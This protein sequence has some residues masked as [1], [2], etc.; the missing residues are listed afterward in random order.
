M[1]NLAVI[2]FGKSNSGKTTTIRAFA[3][4]LLSQNHCK[5][6]CGDINQKS[7]FLV[8][9]NADGTL[10]GIASGGDTAEIINHNLTIF[11]QKGCDIII[12]AAKSSGKTHDEII[13]L[14]S[15]FERIW[16]RQR[17]IS[18]APINESKEERLRC[19]SIKSTI[20]LIHSIIKL[21][22]AP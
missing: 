3:E 22:K 1:T 11:L 8:C 19:T 18:I 12:T 7:D 10:I 6:V 20:E 17:D 9:I 14:C 2:V 5:R 16:L 13:N 15:K 21:A 4:E